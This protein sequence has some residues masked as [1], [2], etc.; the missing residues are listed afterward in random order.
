MRLAAWRRLMRWGCAA[1]L[2]SQTVLTIAAQVP[3][4]PTE[5]RFASSCSCPHRVDG[6]CPMHHASTPRDQCSCR[7]P[8]DHA[9]VTLLFQLFA[10]MPQDTVRAANQQQM[11]LTQILRPDPSS[12][13]DEPTSPPPRA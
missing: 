3:L 4:L 11:P 10:V 6:D 13:R 5:P 1:W 2:L 7:A 8:D 9:D 12:R